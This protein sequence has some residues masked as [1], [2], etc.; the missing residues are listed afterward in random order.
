MWDHEDMPMSKLGKGAQVV[1]M[2][3]P[4]LMSAHLK[5]TRLRWSRLCSWRRE[6]WESTITGIIFNRAK[7][8]SKRILM[9]SSSIWIFMTWRRN[10]PT[11]YSTSSSL[12]LQNWSCP[13]KPKPLK[14]PRVTLILFRKAQKRRQNVLYAHSS[15]IKDI[16][17]Q[18][19]GS[20]ETIFKVF[21]TCQFWPC[22][23]SKRFRKLFIKSRPENHIKSAFKWKYIPE[24]V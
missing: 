14:L 21:N 9:W 20:C 23:L 15:R 12:N 3:Q 10:N 6:F 17:R 7:S 13:M 19:Y 24:N 1:K 4:C 8:S 16:F 11:P 2:S 5:E 22:D 18:Y